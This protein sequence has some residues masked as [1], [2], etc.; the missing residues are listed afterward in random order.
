VRIR[1]SVPFL[2]VAFLIAAGACK[3]EHPP[4]PKPALGSSSEAGPLLHAGRTHVI[5]LII[6]T[7]RADKMGAYGFTSPTS[8]DL[9]RFA[10][11]GVRFE[12]VIAQCS[13]TRPSIGSMLTGRYPRSLGL[14]EE[15]GQRLGGSHQT[16]AEVFEVHGYTTIGVT[17]NPNIN[18]VFGFDQGFDAYVD[19]RRIWPWMKDDDADARKKATYPGQLMPATEV[20]E[21]VWRLLQ[22]HPEGPYFIQ[23]NIMEMHGWGPRI[24]DELQDAF[25]GEKDAQYLAKLRQASIDV[26]AFVSRWLSTE[27]LEDTLLVITSDHGEGLSDH[28][29]IENA[30]GH[31]L[32]LYETQLRVPLILYHSK[33]VLGRGVVIERPVR[34]MDLHPT[35]VDLFGFEVDRD[36]DGVSLRPVITDPGSDIPLPELFV[37]ETYFQDA[38]KQ[39]VYAADW[40][41]YKHMDGWKGMDSTELQRPGSPELGS[42]TNQIMR[43]PEQATRFEAFLEAWERQ[44]EKV[45]PIVDGNLPDELIEQL[46]A[47]GY[48]D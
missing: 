16:L 27:A 41:F 46:R 28:P 35:L 40:N 8:P 36:I 14:Y 20:F 10:A 15:E 39:S 38:E 1:S 47:I 29:G 6:D 2:L 4:A 24:R 45:D 13:W 19:S 42:R 44:H 22:K 7:L 25:E 5:F 23:L 3:K 21:H 32:T 48:L 17:A 34:L 26:G 43:H 9:D 37:A 18:A 30:H 11:A 12:N 31:G 33:G